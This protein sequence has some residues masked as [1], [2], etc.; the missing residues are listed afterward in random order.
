[1]SKG[2]KSA[3][4]LFINGRYIVNSTTSSAIMNAY[5]SYLM[6]RQYPVYVLKVEMPR[7]IV[8]VNVHPTKADVRFSDN[9]IVYG[10]IYSVVSHVLD[11]TN[12]ALEISSDFD[13]NSDTHNDEIIKVATE[14]KEEIELSK[15]LSDSGFGN[16]DFLLFDS[17]VKHDSDS[18]VTEVLNKKEEEF[19]TKS[20]KYEDIFA[21]NKAYLESLER[22]KK[23]LAE[24]ERKT[25]E[26]KKPVQEIIETLPELQYVGQVLNTYLVLQDG[27]NVYFIDQHAAHE[28]ILYDKL[29]SSVTEKNIAVQPLL[30]PYTFTL[31][32]LESSFFAGKIAFLNG[33]GIE[34][35]EFGVNSYK[36]SAIPSVLLDMDLEKFIEDVVGDMSNL[37]EN[38]LPEIITE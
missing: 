3:Q 25:V 27:T 4:T 5:S 34:T 36:I 28:R 12:Q 18:T 9:Q 16:E 22:K 23:M 21:E 10:S 35:E 26:E 33:L 2:N 6:K 7:E 29:L 8:D 13:N 32:G 14:L 1:M 38:E 15:K 30:L 37:T 31:S 20:E 11:G 24:A 17:G 19:K